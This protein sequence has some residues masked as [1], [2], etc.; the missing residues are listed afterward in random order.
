[1][2]A[3][4]R[5][6]RLCSVDKG[7]CIGTSALIGEKFRTRNCKEYPVLKL[8]TC[9]ID[10]QACNLEESNKQLT[11]AGANAAKQGWGEPVILRYAI[12]KL[13]S[14]GTQEMGIK[15]KLAAGKYGLYSIPGEHENNANVK[16]KLESM[17]E[18]SMMANEDA[19]RVSVS[20]GSERQPVQE[21]FKI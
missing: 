9:F 3:R 14:L 5:N 4:T 16:L 10:M 1:M 2:C 20:N 18:Q 6:K 7:Y 11:N 8:N 17:G 13:L 12:Q 21:Q 15:E 19:L